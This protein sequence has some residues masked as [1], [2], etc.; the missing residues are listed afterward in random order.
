MAPDYHCSLAD[1]FLRRADREEHQMANGILAFLFLC[2]LS[3]IGS[4]SACNST[5]TRLASGEE[6]AAAV[7]EAERDL[8]EV[9]AKRP[10]Q[11]DRDVLATATPL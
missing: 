11:D 10:S 7:Q 1:G 3:V 8:A 9:R 4:L 6:I 5:P 2:G